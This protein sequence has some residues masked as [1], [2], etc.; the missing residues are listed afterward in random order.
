LRVRSKMPQ[1]ESIFLRGETSRGKSFYTQTSG[2]QKRRG[3][4]DPDTSSVMGGKI[5]LT[6]LH[7]I[8]EGNMHAHF[9][10]DDQRVFD[11]LTLVLQARKAS[12]LSS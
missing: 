10:L 4:C 2:R 8:K 3:I 6:A 12:R 7:I 1:A 5:H 11:M 9:L